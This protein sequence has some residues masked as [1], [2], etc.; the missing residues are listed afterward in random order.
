[1]L[2]RFALA[3]L[4]LCTFGHRIQTAITIVIG[5]IDILA[6][7]MTPTSTTVAIDVV[8][9]E[10]RHLLP[11]LQLPPPPKVM[12]QSLDLFSR[13]RV[14]QRVAPV[15]ADASC[16]CSRLHLHCRLNCRHQSVVVVVVDV[17]VREGHHHKRP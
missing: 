8:V 6:I 17:G 1:L 12:Q 9:V 4:L 14:V 11:L 2:R 3:I 7:A 5:I 15:A 16:S 13:Q 10:G